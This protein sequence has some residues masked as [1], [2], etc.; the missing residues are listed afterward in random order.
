[1]LLV[2]RSNIGRI[3]IANFIIAI[4]RG[5]VAV[6]RSVIAILMS[7]ATIVSDIVANVKNI[8]SSVRSNTAPTV[9][10]P[11][12]SDMPTATTMAVVGVTSIIIL[13]ERNATVRL[14]MALICVGRPICLIVPFL[15]G[16]FVG[17][18]VDLLD[19]CIARLLPR[20]R[21]NVFPKLGGHEFVERSVPL[22]FGLLGRRIFRQLGRYVDRAI[23]VTDSFN[24]DL[25]SA[26]RMHSQPGATPSSNRRATIQSFRQLTVHHLHRLC[27]L[28]ALPR[29]ET[30]VDWEG[31]LLERVALQLVG[32]EI[33]SWGT[34]H[35][36]SNI[37]LQI[38]VAKPTSLQNKGNSICALEHEVNVEEVVRAHRASDLR[39]V[40]HELQ[41]WPQNRFVTGSANAEVCLIARRGSEF[42]TG[43]AVE[44]HDRE[45]PRSADGYLIIVHLVLKR[46]TGA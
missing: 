41:R 21:L 19:W 34:H 32:D 24:T 10:T 1:M 11:T 44:S 40:V 13:V 16:V 14:C 6:V 4:V 25:D 33:V 42:L 46:C 22:I 15:R 43:I 20:P 23:L 5:I 28:I 2:W 37:D 38:R 18:L 26:D 45:I 17:V 27:A 9:T 3:A 29:G 8:F 36:A 12:T 30:Y 39:Q 7:V 31:R 35:S